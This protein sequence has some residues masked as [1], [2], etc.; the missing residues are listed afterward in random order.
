MQCYVLYMTFSWQIIIKEL[1]QCYFWMLRKY[2]IIFYW[3]NCW[4]SCK[5]F[6]YY[7]FWQNKFNHFYQ[8][9]LSVLSLMKKE[10]QIRKLNLKYYKVHQFHLYCFWYISDFCLLKSKNN[11][12]IYKSKYLTIL[13]MWLW[14]L[15][16]NQQKKIV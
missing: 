14:W 13:M 2:L 11:T 4:K 12:Q 16:A 5:I 10:T 3:I 9:E 1:F 15:R 7:I 6:I 8:I